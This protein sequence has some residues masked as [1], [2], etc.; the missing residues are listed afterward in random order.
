MKKIIALIISMVTVLSLFSFSVS[1]QG[2]EEVDDTEEEALT[3]ILLYGN[4]EVCGHIHVVLTGVVA[5]HVR[6]TCIRPA[7][8][9]DSE[10]G[11]CIKH[12]C[13][14]SCIGH[15]NVFTEYTPKCRYGRIFRN[16]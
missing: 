13:N 4:K 11:E 7:E 12:N 2:E 5:K 3:E 14:R 10:G 1:A 9:E 15:S 16:K 6:H 8:S